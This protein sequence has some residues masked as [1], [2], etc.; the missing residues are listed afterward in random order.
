MWAE[1]VLDFLTHG[2]HGLVEDGLDE[3]HT[4]ATSCAGFGAGFDVA[5]RLA[6]SVFHGC[7]DVAFQNV[8][9]GAHL[10]VII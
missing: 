8:V 3:R 9:A 1:V 2:G 4:A 10:G 7:S 5:D 6:S